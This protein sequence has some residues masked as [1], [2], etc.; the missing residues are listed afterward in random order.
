MIIKMDPMLGKEKKKSL[1]FSERESFL[2]Q[3]SNS[4]A[5]KLEMRNNFGKE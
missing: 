1:I 4:N 3:Y 5:L 2:S